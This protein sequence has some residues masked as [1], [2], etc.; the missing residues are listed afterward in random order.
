MAEPNKLDEPLSESEYDDLEAFFGSN[1]VPQDCM[2]LE[3][4][5]GFLTSIVSGPEMIQPSEWLPVVWSDSQRSVSPVFA[6]N[7]QAE[8][9]LALL[10]RLQNS[11]AR[12]LNESPTRFKPLLYRPEDGVK[13]RE[14]PGEGARR[15][16]TAP[17]EASAWC[18][19]YM[20]GVLLREEAWE[21]IY[22][23]DATRDWMLPIEALAY[24]DHDPEYLDW[25]DS[26]DKR[27]GLIDELPVAAVLIHRFWLARRSGEGVSRAE[28][29]AERREASRKVRQRLH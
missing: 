10:L 22:A 13:G 15:E 2:D 7:E 4:L 26:E 6:D 17:P 23:S 21:P 8:R 11:I 18:E 16:E 12:T 29:R 5:D 25:V 19:G 14:S 27:E 28:R 3:M 20:T 1:A 9:I 24:G